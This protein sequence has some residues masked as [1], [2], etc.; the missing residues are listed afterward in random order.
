[1]LWCILLFYQIFLRNLIN[2][3]CQNIYE[4]IKITNYV[5]VFTFFSLLLSHSNGLT[6]SSLYCCLAACL[7]VCLAVCLQL[8]SS[9]LFLSAGDWLLNG[10][11]NPCDWQLTDFTKCS[12]GTTQVYELLSVCVFAVDDVTITS[13]Q[14]DYLLV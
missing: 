1:M 13:H 10:R 12:P 14:E 9:V 11:G 2:Y 3:V 7:P 8:Q 6:L 5:D 4:N